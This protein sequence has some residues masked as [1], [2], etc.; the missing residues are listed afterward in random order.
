LKT[1]SSSTAGSCAARVFLKLTLALLA[2]VAIIA[3]GVAGAQSSRA[4][5]LPRR[6]GA[7][8]AHSAARANNSSQPQTAMPQFSVTPGVYAGTQ[9]VT[10]TDSTPGA[11]IYYSTD[12]AYPI[13]NY[14]AYTSPITISSSEVVVAYAVA[15]GYANSGY[16]IGRYI[17]ST[18][19]SSFVY[20]IAGNGSWGYSGDGGPAVAAQ[21][22]TYKSVALDAAGN[23]YIADPEARVVR[24]VT[25]SS[26]MISTIA[27]TGLPG[28]AGD[29]GPATSATLN[30]PFNLVVDG[31]GNVYIGEENGII[32]LVTASTGQISTYASVANITGMAVD[33]SNDLYV[34]NSVNVLKFNAQTGVSTTLPQNSYP[35]MVGLA[36]D[37]H[38][39]AYFTEGGYGAVEELNAQT[40]AI[41]IVAGSNYG[42]SSSGDGGPATSARLYASAV[43]F[44]GSGNM[45]ILDSGDCAV[46]KVQNGIISTVFGNWTCGSV[47]AD[48][49]PATSVGLDI[50][51]A[52]NFAVGASGQI[53]IAPTDARVWEVTVPALPPTTTLPAPQFSASAGTYA[54]PQTVSVSSSVAGASIYL[55]TDGS[56]PSTRYGGYYGPVNAAGTMTVTAVASAPGYLPSAPV[57]AKYTITA[58][59]D[60]IISTV[61]GTGMG[62][63]TNTGG[64][65][66]TT[67]F[68]Y[69]SDAVA[70]SNGNVYF[71]DTTN[72]LVWKFAAATGN[73]SVFAGCGLPGSIGD[74]GPATSA[75]FESV[76]ALAVD[77]AGNV[78]IADEDTGRVRMVS[79][80]TG[81]ITTVAGPG[82][83]LV[84]GDGGPATAAYLGLPISLA[85]DSAGN[86]YIGDL[87]HLRV[88]MVSAATGII[89]TF[90]GGGT[91]GQP[92]DGGPANAAYLEPSHLAVD[93]KNNLYILDTENNR[94][95][96][97]DSNTGVISSIAGNGFYGSSG[98]GG[99]ATEAEISTAAGIA[100]D[101]QG[102]IYLS[103]SPSQIRKID[104][105]T[106]IISGVVGTGYDGYGGDGGS[107]EAASLD[108]QW[109]L[110]FDAAGNMYIADSGNYV[111]RKVT[112]PAPAATPSFSLAAGAYTGVQKVSITDSAANA[113]IYYTTDGSTPDTGSTAYSGPIT[114][115]SNE[116]IEAIAV[117]SGDAQSAVASADYAITIP[118]PTITLAS[119]ANPSFTNNGVTFTAT[120]SSTYGTP[121]G[122]VNFLDGTTQ[123]GS[124][125]VSNGVATYAT[126]SLSVGTHS[127][128]AVYAGD[129]NF[130]TA[131]SAAVTETIEDF[132]FGPPS[133]G[134][135]TSATASP[136]GTATYTLTVTPPSGGTSASAITFSISGLPTG[137]TATFSPAT[138]PANSGTTN[139]TLTINVPAS[140]A[141]Q[142]PA[143]PFEGPAPLVLGLLLLPLA[144]M[145]SVRRRL[146]GKALLL[147]VAL[148]GGLGL[149]AVTGCGGSGSSGSSTPQPQT[150][151]LT[152]TATAGSLTHTTNLT[153]TVQ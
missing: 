33:A 123:L 119:S 57:S 27:G 90:A 138:V 104:A 63:V 47:E 3:A 151:N 23:L 134:G 96:I 53:Y 87:L 61:A 116:T 8:H 50:Q 39:N 127:I 15:S 88:R 135:S 91:F 84:L 125:T 136:G 22:G 12:G 115:S 110:T 85:V 89:S 16:A 103:S 38:G 40:G 86:L 41:T 31:A 6:R 26:G 97:V 14:P 106:G 48:G 73:L 94:L 146:H 145:R 58:P 133:S 2:F 72:Y 68:G 129:A 102:N 62:V 117:V 139:V 75:E 29:G 98:N 60:A 42:V 55:S 71:A 1:P 65:A 132:T 28:D 82:N 37:A 13:G 69:L 36:V 148:I 43:A 111:V 77:N 51:Y 70:D 142:I 74:G 120:L 81:I 150:Y 54:D 46:R 76:S 92:G 30:A 95:R 126:S 80:A 32:R 130:T 64:P 112:Y 52:T 17:I 121:T 93:A 122:T 141:A 153:L 66:L 56:T 128:T 83:Q 11:T 21:L 113:T 9:T 7:P 19:P 67:S 147:A 79:A 144:G 124:G 118:T 149:V 25:A 4:P 59:P 131:T 49:D 108:E 34:T 35:N 140:A 101:S 137:A 107:A 114:V 10:I 152:V 143:R 44:D 24:K 45:Y 100:L 78:Y 20:S 18:V 105:K 109:G 5:Q 99:P